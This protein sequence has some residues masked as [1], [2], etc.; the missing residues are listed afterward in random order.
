MGVFAFVCAYSIVILFWAKTLNFGGDY[1]LVFNI[2]A[3]AIFA[4]FVGE[5]LVVIPIVI[6]TGNGL[7]RDVHLYDVGLI[8]VW[9]INI[10]TLLSYSIWM[11]GYGVRLQIRLAHQLSWDSENFLKKITE[12]LRINGVLTICTICYIIRCVCVFI[13]INGLTK[14]PMVDIPQAKYFVWYI[15]S[16]WIP[17]VIP[18]SNCILCIYVIVFVYM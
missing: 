17:N 4:N 15:V 7:I 1:D 8:V 9:S 16:Q 12:L 18:V 6:Y 13:V 10:V 3:F 14:K 11:F 2:I 5:I